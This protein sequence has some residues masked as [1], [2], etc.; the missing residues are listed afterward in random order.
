VQKLI[1]NITLFYPKSIKPVG[2]TKFK[3]INTILNFDDLYI[4]AVVTAITSDNYHY[5]E[6]N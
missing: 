2:V 5:H 3:P 6:N 1:K 4:E